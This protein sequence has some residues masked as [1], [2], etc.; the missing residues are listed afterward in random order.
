MA[1][2]QPKT[3]GILLDENYDNLEYKTS[4][5]WYI[6]SIWERRSTE[7]LPV[8]EA[9]RELGGLTLRLG[10][11]RRLLGKIRALSDDIILNNIG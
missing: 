3:S 2:E 8:G 9:L 5:Y 10:P 6:R 1:K 7:V 11:H 4:R